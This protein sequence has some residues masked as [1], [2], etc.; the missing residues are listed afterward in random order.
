MFEHK[1]LDGQWNKAIPATDSFISSEVLECRDTVGDEPA[2]ISRKQYA[3]IG[4]HLVERCLP[5]E[6]IGNTW[7]YDVAQLP[8]WSAVMNPPHAGIIA[9]FNSQN[10]GL[11][12]RHLDVAHYVVG[13]ASAG[14]EITLLDTLYH[15][16]R[17]SD[18]TALSAS[19]MLELR[20]LY[21]A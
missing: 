3:V 10:G 17:S 15:V 11:H 14:E 8:W 6:S 21:F 2:K 7:A 9:E 12:R 13:Y 20:K 18:G 5:P 4:D 19:S 16:T 1:S